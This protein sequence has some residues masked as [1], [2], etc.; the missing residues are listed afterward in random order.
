MR[1][2]MKFLSAIMFSTALFV[3]CDNQEVKVPQ[4]VQSAFETEYPDASGVDWEREGDH[5]KVE[6]RANDL[7]IEIT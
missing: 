1:K 7:E 5:Y 4:E 3:A 2:T 6:F